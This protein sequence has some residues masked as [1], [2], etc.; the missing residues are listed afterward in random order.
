MIK[1]FLENNYLKK[2]CKH[3]EKYSQEEFK[4][5]I[6]YLNLIIKKDSKNDEYKEFFNLLNKYKNCFDFFVYTSIFDK[7]NHYN[8]NNKYKNYK[9][10]KNELL[11]KIKNNN[12]SEI[13][14]S[15]IGSILGMAIGD[16]IG[17]RVEFMHY[18]YNSDEV[19]DMGK[20]IAGKFNL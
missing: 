6:H 16:A 19:K 17:S 13:E 15:C 5:G 3:V 11:N 9:R 18:T 10:Y 2:E 1:N 8:D 7:C 14:D 12:F 4:Y 20:G